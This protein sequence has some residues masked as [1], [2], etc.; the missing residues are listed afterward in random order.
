MTRNEMLKALR[1]S[2]SILTYGLSLLVRKDF[3]YIRF[4]AGADYSLANPAFKAEKDLELRMMLH[5][6]CKE[7]VKST[8]VWT[9]SSVEYSYQSWDGVPF[10]LC[11]E[12]KLRHYGFMN[13]LIVAYENK[14]ALTKSRSKRLKCDKTYFNFDM[15]GS[16]P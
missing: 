7:L 3:V 16:K 1:K 9:E 8:T 14:Y 10:C 12:L 5:C 2:D 6:L 13:D 11:C 15:R 4:A